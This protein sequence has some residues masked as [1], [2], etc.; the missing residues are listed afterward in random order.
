MT[1]Q[2]V[3]PSIIITNLMVMLFS[4][5]LFWIFFQQSIVNESAGDVV[6]FGVIGISFVGFFAANFIP[7]N[8]KWP[9]KEGWFRTL[10]I[11]FIVSLC[12][13]P[14]MVAGTVVLIFFT[15][16]LHITRF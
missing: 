12:A 1:T 6:G 3:F 5:F 8:R 7:L 15:Q 16:P 11:P 13:T 2:S 14:A 10:L 9:H 4:F